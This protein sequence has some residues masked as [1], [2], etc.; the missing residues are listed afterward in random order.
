MNT[1]APMQRVRP[2]SLAAAV[3]SH[4]E[5]GSGFRYHLASFLDGFYIDPSN[6]R[7]R[8]RLV[9]TPDLRGDQRFDGWWELLGNTSAVGGG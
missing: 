5:T 9:D 8:E 1:M 6:R 4:L 2:G 7:R 3:H